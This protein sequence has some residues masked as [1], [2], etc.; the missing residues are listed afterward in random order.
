MASSAPS[1]FNERLLAERPELSSS[2]AA[3]P[4]QV[5]EIDL[6]AIP[7]DHE[8]PHFLNLNFMDEIKL[9]T[10]KL[11]FFIQQFLSK[12]L[13]KALFKI[14]ERILVKH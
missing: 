10:L 1:A 5:E 12:I 14:T 4:G 11:S 9:N 2:N 13:F 6:K 3:L 8:T 7:D